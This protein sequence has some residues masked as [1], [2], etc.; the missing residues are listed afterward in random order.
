MYSIEKNLKAGVLLSLCLGLPSLALAEQPYRESTPVPNGLYTPAAASGDAKL[1]NTWQYWKDPAKPHEEFV[2]N[3]K[4][5]WKLNWKFK[6]APYNGALHGGHVAQDRGE[7]LYKG[8]N[9]SGEFATCLGAKNGN[10]KGLRLTYPHFD[11]TQGKV[12]TLEGEIK[13]CAAKQGMELEYG[14]YDNSA[15]SVYI[16]A[17]SNGMPIN[18]DV[19][20]GPM[21]AAFERGEQAFH[22]KTGRFNMG[23][24]TCHVQLVGEN[25]RGQT[26]TTHFGDAGHWPTYRSKEELQGLH[27][28]FTECNRNS[29]TQPLKP[30]SQPYVDLEVFLTA[31][32]N[33]YPVSLPST[34]D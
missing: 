23:C 29:G 19:T 27:I 22:L 28:R 26:L 1:T 7:E 12:V 32:T 14:S 17:F 33:G 24:A 15:I 11:K 31:L 21:K 20:Q 3:G 6:D 30:G 8:L 18:L 34:R 25:L 2:G 10:L 9:K 16:G 5:E 4:N 13:R